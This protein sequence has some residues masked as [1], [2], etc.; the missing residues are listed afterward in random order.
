MV[1]F[2]REDEDIALANLID[3]LQKHTDEEIFFIKVTGG[4]FDDCCII[5]YVNKY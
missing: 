1:G 4:L 5:P 2:T 3:S